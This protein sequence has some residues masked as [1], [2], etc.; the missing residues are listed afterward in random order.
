MALYTP[1]PP[2]RPF[3]EDKPTLLVSWWVAGLCSVV[4]TL[5]LAGRYTRVEKLFIEDK[6]AAIF[7]IPLFLRTAF[8]HI[9]LL[10]GTNNVSLASSDLAFSDEEVRRRSIGSGLVLLTRILH[11]AAWVSLFASD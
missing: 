9:V 2:A 5:R 8:L 11:P 7:L 6:I 1:A 3:S 10:Y 4:I